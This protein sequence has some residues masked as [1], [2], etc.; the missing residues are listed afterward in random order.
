MSNTATTR[1][2]ITAHAAAP[3]AF[4]WTALG[5]VYVVWGSTYLGIR[6]AVQAGLPPLVSG[7]VRFIVAGLLL[8]TIIAVRRRPGTLRVSRRQL[9]SAALAGALLL[10]GGNG[11]V[12]VAEQTVPS[13]L[14]A[15][16]IAAVPL[17]IVVLRGV[18]G[19]RPHR[20]TILGVLGGL[21]GLAVLCLPGS[22]ASGASALGIGLLILAPMF[23]SLGS[24]LSSRVA[25]PRDPFVATV[26]EMLAG[27]S[28]MLVVGLARGELA[29]FSPAD[30]SA[31][32]WVALAYLVVFGSIAAFTSYIWLLQ[33]ARLSL[34]AT[35]A[36]VNPVVAV[37]LGALIL[38][39]A[40]TWPILVGG[41]IVVLGVGIVVTT[42]RPRPH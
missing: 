3:A 33:N 41:A 32:G 26:W 6:I 10:F 12:M 15:L 27:G 2:P 19:D 1:A 5:I 18:T 38:D 20:W 37:L 39:E 31:S 14:A 7:G 8:A 35:Y 13:G 40:V 21:I 42:E 30:T 11:L 29:G 25:M 23:W 34:V 22:S 36:Y 4:V 16:M 24:F 9:A 17:W 28:V